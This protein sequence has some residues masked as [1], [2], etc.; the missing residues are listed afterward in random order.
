MKKFLLIVALFLFT[1][2]LLAS[3]QN[4]GIQVS[5]LED[6]KYVDY[7]GLGINDIIWTVTN[8]RSNMTC[9]NGAAQSAEDFA[10]SYFYFDLAMFDGKGGWMQNDEIEV[11]VEIKG[12][13]PQEKGTF[14]FNARTDGFSLF[15]NVHYD[16]D[17]DTETYPGEGLI[18]E[19]KVITLS[20]DKAS[21][22]FCKGTASG[23]STQLTASINEG[24]LTGITWKTEAGGTISGLSTPK[25]G[26]ADFSGVGVGEYKVVAEVNGTRSKVIP[27][28]V[29]QTPAKPVLSVSPVSLCAQD[30][31]TFTVTNSETGATYKWSPAPTSGSGTTV[32]YKPA[33]TS[34]VNYSVEANLDGCIAKSDNKTLQFKPTIAVSG[35]PVLACEIGYYTAKITVNAGGDQLEIAN[36]GNFT[37]PVQNA[38]W[39]GR[40]V[41]LDKLPFG[42]HTFYI[43]DTKDACG[44]IPVTVNKAEA[45]CGCEAQFAITGNSEF[46]VGATAP[47][48]R[49]TL[50][51]NSA[52]FTEWSFVLKDPD[53][54]AV[55]T[56]D[57]VS[58]NTK[59]FEYIPTKS[60]KYTLEGAEAFDNNGNGCGD[61]NGEPFVTVKI[62]PLPVINDFVVSTDKGCVGSDLTLTATATGGTGT[63]SY[64][65]SGAGASGTAST[66]N[67]KV[68]ANENEYSFVV[69]DQKNC[70]A[71]SGKKTV[72]GYSVTVQALADRTSVDNG[73]SA[74]LDCNVTLTPPMGSTVQSYKWEPANMIDGSNGQKQ[75]KTVA[76]TK[77]QQYT[78]TV[79]NDIGCEASA[80]VSIAVGAPVLNAEATGSEGCANTTLTAEATATGGGSTNYSYTWKESKPAGLT[81]SSNSTKKVTITNADKVPAGTYLIPV[82]VSDNAGQTKTVEAEVIIRGLVSATGD[83]L[84]LDAS[85]FDGMIKVNSGKQPYKLYSDQAATNE[86]TG[87]Q[88]DGNNGTV[89]GL[90]SD[91]THTYYV[92]DADRC[93]TVRVDLSANCAC[94]AQLNMNLG[95]Q[96][97]AQP[98]AKRTI[99]LTA[100]GG[101]SYSFKLVHESGTI[102]KSV[103]RET[104][105]EWVIEVGYADRGEYRI[106]NF[107]AVTAAVADGCEG[108]VTTRTVKVDFLPIPQVSA[109]EDIIACGLDPITLK[110]NGDTGLTFEWDNGVQDGVPFT[111][112]MGETTY[113]VRGTNA[114]GCWNEA[115]V[116]VTVSEKPMVSAMATPPMICKGES[117]AL[118][119]HGTADTYV[120][121]NGG[122]EGEGNMPETT[123]R[124]TVTGTVDATGCSDTASVLVVVNMPAEITEAPKDRSIAIGKDVNFTVKA[125]GNNLTY[126]WQWY[127]ADSDSWNTFTDNT[128]S[129]PKVSGATTEEL[130][131]EEVP[132]SWDGRKVKCVVQGD[133]GAP[134]EAEATLSVKECFDILGDIAM[135]EGIIPETGENTEVDG[136][137]CKGNRI[138]VK[139]LIELADPEYGE[140]SFSHYTWTIDGLPADKVIES[141]SSI[142]TWIP[143]Y[144]EDDI[145]VK[146]GVYCD[147]ACEEVYSKALRLKARMPDDVKLNILTSVDPDKRFCPGDTITFTAALENDKPGSE[148]HWY[149]D[150]FDRGR[151]LTKVFVMDQQDTWVRAVFEPAADM[152]VEHEVSDS[153]FLRV[154]PWVQ[155]ILS[156]DNNIHDTIACQGDSLI[157]RANWEHAGNQPT[158]IWHQDIWERGYG[159]YAT[160]HLND[161]DTWVKCEL[162]PGNDVCY[163]G[164]RIVDT[165]VVRVIEPGTLT[166]ECDM[167]D[168]HFG[169]ELVFISTVGGNVGEHWNYNWFLNNGMLLDQTEPV[170]SSNDL[171]QGDRVQASIVGNEICVNRIWSNE[172]A[173]NYKNYLTRDTMVT[174]F[175]GEKIT[176]LNMF[177]EGDTG[178]YFIISEYPRNGQASM[179]PQTGEFSYTPNRDFV[180]VDLVTYRVQKPGDKTDFEEGTIF[181]TVEAGGLL[182]I[183]NIITPNGDGVNDVWNLQKIT[184][185]YSEYVITV[186]S[187]SGR[188]VWQARNDYDN[189]FDGQGNGNG[190][191][192]VPSLPSGIYT[193]VIDLNRG[194]R[195][196]VSWLE[197]RTTFNRGYY[198]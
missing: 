120:W 131:L 182:D 44:S 183:P 156:I 168:K 100:T 16:Q 30:E 126:Q 8:K 83:A 6:G 114:A 82:T 103:D 12:S 29:K 101:I 67:M 31:A 71:T 137:Y 122:V 153:V 2:T 158:L 37:S 140:V 166:I 133:C 70:S 85:T 93:N 165:M 73:Q 18:I 94:G 190:T 7:V 5:L 25:L 61:I 52:K 142:L 34:V 118:E 104:D 129:F 193:Y 110:A 139:A 84:C 76:L 66:V 159:E 127:H 195:K 184:E 63:L 121:D 117:L 89:S 59:F 119:S 176:N 150:I 145:V 164:E 173:V 17:T 163:A 157:F 11:T 87:V 3:N 79:R 169:D 13:S 111:P 116:I 179:N 147:G 170:Y 177:K 102:L 146:V 148:V 196:L 15:E 36:D 143:E 22:S 162:K 123:T 95:E 106:E 187:R 62:N 40:T 14:I 107:T 124:Y 152:C 91:Q 50:T 78:V 96:A 90:S 53:G 39:S 43:R 57:K 54:A 32:K 33:N 138:A 88:W 192:F 112:I 60:G 144:Y 10:D 80:N 86:V 48:I 186:Y 188:I 46:C 181:I 26:V 109:G 20:I 149:R 24:T 135:G 115:S 65:W 197:I 98:D 189:Q 180:G 92:Q 58:V 113:T 125:I 105:S 45:A 19:K 108:N 27:V 56:K 9:T 55:L 178:R 49:V 41:T 72:T 194:E 172:I 35:T 74:N 167:T 99:T 1:L 97:C 4:V 128:T 51:T 42:Q 141:D 191:Y 171:K 64:R 134:A 151:G 23:P 77:A 47:K 160:I 69:T 38:T 174:I 136:W 75:V 161:R 185:K 28:S 155:P 130:L 81:L 175:V 132:E 68:Q 198:R 154:K 21:L